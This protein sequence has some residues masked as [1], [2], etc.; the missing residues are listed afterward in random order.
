[1]HTHLLTQKKYRKMDFYCC[2]ER[3]DM[4]FL[5]KGLPKAIESSL[6]MVQATCSTV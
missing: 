5:S 3:T 4:V 2:K 1:M 6:V